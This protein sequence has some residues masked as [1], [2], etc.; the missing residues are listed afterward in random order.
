MKKTLTKEY[1]TVKNE[2]SEV[3]SQ[4]KERNAG[5]KKKKE[6]EYKKNGFINTRLYLGR[7]AY[8]R[9]SVVYETLLG[10]KLDYDGQDKNGKKAKKSIDNLSRVISYCIVKLY[11]ELYIR[12]DKNPVDKNIPQI[13]PAETKA[14][15]ELYDFYQLISYRTADKERNKN[16]MSELINGDI[17]IPDIINN[18]TRYKAKSPHRMNKII[19]DI[20]D[21]TELEYLIKSANKK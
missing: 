15:Q 17:C 7:D 12:K 20:Q 16:L 4:K 18:N 14:A 6:D 3:L 8:T 11:H 9:L 5:Y 1:I 13:P 10:E 19:N 21:T 2:K